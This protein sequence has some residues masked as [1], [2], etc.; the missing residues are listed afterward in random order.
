[1]YVA[2]KYFFNYL[3]KIYSFVNTWYQRTEGTW[4]WNIMK[5]LEIKD[6]VFKNSIS[7]F[8]RWFKEPVKFLWTLFSVAS[9]S[10]WDHVFWYNLSTNHNGENVIPNQIDSYI[11]TDWLIYSSVLFATENETLGW[12]QILD[13]LKVSGELWVG[14]WCLYRKNTWQKE[15]FY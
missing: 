3:H 10:Q 9:V 5:M 2:I 6:I 7:I 1:M 15:L 4:T 13:G 11:H 12:P 14:V 8:A